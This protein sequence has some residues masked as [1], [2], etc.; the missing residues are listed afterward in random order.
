MQ[1]RCRFAISIL[2]ANSRDMYEMG[3]GANIND[4]NNFLKF[5]FYSTSEF[6][7]GRFNNQDFDQLVDKVRYVI[8]W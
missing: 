4:P 5:L 7:Y 2:E 1:D 3:W 6:N 8:S